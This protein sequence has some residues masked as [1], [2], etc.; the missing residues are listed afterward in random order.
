MRATR[1]QQ[2]AKLLNRYTGVTSNTAHSERVDGI[3][4]GYRQNALTIAHDDVLTLTHNLESS[5]FQCAHCIEMIDP[6]GLRQG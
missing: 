1:L 2:L 3:V 4:A 5:L 6:G